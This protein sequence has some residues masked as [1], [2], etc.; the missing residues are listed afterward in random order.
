MLL[1]ISWGLVQVCEDAVVIN[2]DQ[3]YNFLVD[4]TQIHATVLFTDDTACKQFADRAPKYLTS[5]LTTTR[6]RAIPS[7]NGTRAR[8]FVDKSKYTNVIAKDMSSLVAERKKEAEALEAEAR[9]LANEASDASKRA[10][11]AKRN[12]KDFAKKKAAIEAK[13]E[14]VLFCPTLSLTAPLFLTLVSLAAGKGVKCV[15][16]HGY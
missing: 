2:N 16:G 7:D 1:T 3:V 12:I 8:W 15:A 4:R 9:E 5:A 13:Q 11:A 10:S 6:G 14:K